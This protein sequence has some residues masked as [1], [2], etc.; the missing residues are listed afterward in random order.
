MWKNIVEPDRPR[1]TI[2]RMRFACLTTKVTDTH[3][4][5]VILI[6][7]SLQEWLSERR[8]VVCY[9]KHMVTFWFRHWRGTEQQVAPVGNCGVAGAA[10]DGI[11][12]ELTWKQFNDF[13]VRF[14]SVRGTKY[15]DT[16]V[17]YVFTYC[18]TILFSFSKS[19]VT[20]LMLAVTMVKPA[21]TWSDHRALES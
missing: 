13:L 14:Q 3:S 15:V 4:E 16:F 1:I 9:N 10:L 6:T 11:Y 17:M 2:Q 21:G 18:A 8:S 19:A 12:R 7:F 5:C 20:L